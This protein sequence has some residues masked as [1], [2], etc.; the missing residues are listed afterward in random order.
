MRAGLR[1]SRGPLGKRVLG[2]FEVKILVSAWACNPRQGSEAA[3]GWGWLSAIKDQHEVHVLTAQYQRDWIEAE[4][5]RAPNQFRG[6]QFRNISVDR[7]GYGNRSRCS[8][9]EEGAHR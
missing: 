1:I 4:I 9:I 3:V 7:R 2:A 5:T 8:A 6:V